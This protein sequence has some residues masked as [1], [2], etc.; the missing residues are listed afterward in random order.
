[1][2]FPEP[3][4]GFAE[5]PPRRFQCG[6]QTLAAHRF[7]ADPATLAHPGAADALRALAASRPLALVFFPNTDATSPAEA[8][9]VAGPF[10][11]CFRLFRAPAT[12]ADLPPVA[13]T[14]AARAIRWLAPL[15]LA[16]P[17]LRLHH[18]RHTWFTAM[19][20]WEIHPARRLPETAEDAWEAGRVTSQLTALR[21]HPD[22][23]PAPAETLLVVTAAHRVL[24]WARA[25]PHADPGGPAVARIHDAFARPGA[26]PAVALLASRWLA[27]EGAEVVAARFTASRWFDAFRACGF[28]LGSKLRGVALSPELAR[29]AGNPGLARCH[30]TD[31]DG[32]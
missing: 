29:A 16:T 26:E 1:V 32:T 27:R 28:S 8:G 22:E 12:A 13:G 7:T 9:W 20:N 17:L 3:P 23:N 6:A 2:P 25:T 21:S 14:P 10:A 31:A 15:G 24:G 18:R 19:D 11:E 5:L 30:L 4:S